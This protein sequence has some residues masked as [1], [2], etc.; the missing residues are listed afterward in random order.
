MFQTIPPKARNRACRDRNLELRPEA[1]ALTLKRRPPPSTAESPSSFA[2]IRD[3]SHP[4][5]ENTHSR[6]RSSR[7]LTSGDPNARHNN[8]PTSRVPA[9][10]LLRIDYLQSDASPVGSAGT[11]QHILFS[12]LLNGALIVRIVPSVGTSS[13]DEA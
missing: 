13:L 1:G 11:P 2:I 6:S 4:P 7:A 10:T 9:A 3:T 5:P 12:H 8:S